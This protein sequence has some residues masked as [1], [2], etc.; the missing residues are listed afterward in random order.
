M[1]DWRRD[2]GSALTGC[3]AE[4][5][6]HE[7]LARHTTFGIGGN[8]GLWIEAGDVEALRRILAFCRSRGIDWWVLGRGSNVLISDQG[9]VGVVVHLCG[10]LARLA[11]EG[12]AIRAGAGVGLDELADRAEQAGL[13]GAEFLAG[14]PGTIGGGLRTNAGAFGR[15]L[16]DVLQSVAVIDPDGRSSVIGRDELGDGYRSPVIPDGVIATEAVLQLD[17]GSCESAYEVRA[18]RRAKQPREASAGSF[19]RNPDSVPAGRLIERCGL[20]GRRVGAARVSEKH[21]NFIVNTGGARFADVY[22]LAQVVKANVE[23]QTG[24]VLQEEVRVL[25]ADRR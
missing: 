3:R 8:A 25:P 14:I 13:C 6:A 2:I 4:C 12:G 16:S 11:V 17:P 5:R 10:D 20:K 22:G 19:F 24:I 23:E 9:L 7:P 15:A 21:A 1:E 18:K